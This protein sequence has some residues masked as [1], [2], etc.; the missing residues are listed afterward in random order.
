MKESDWKIFKQIKEKAI[1]RFCVESLEE[2]QEVIMDQ[3]ENAHNRYLLLY[4]LVQNR[5][6]RMQLLFDN[7][8]RSKA[9]IQLLAIR[10]EGLADDTLLSKLSDEFL[11]KTDPNSHGW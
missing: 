6:K 4:K 3:T 11:K 10:A 9:L 8:S 2:F 1:E 5:D 7:H